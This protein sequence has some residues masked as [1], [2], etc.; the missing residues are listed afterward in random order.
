MISTIALSVALLALTATLAEADELIAIGTLLNNPSAYKVHSV[1]VEGTVK[2]VKHFPPM[3]NRACG[4]MM[5]DSYLLTLEDETGSLN[6]EVFG[7]CRGPGAVIQVSVGER[8]LVQ[9]IFYFP[10]S[11]QVGDMETK[12][13]PFILAFYVDRLTE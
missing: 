1:T 5:Y 13:N 10:R 9:G 12:I 6:V 4:K 11:N 7:G 8:V 3:F 2:E